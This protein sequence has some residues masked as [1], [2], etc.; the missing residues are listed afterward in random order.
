MAVEG[1]WNSPDKARELVSSDQ[2]DC[3]CVS[4]EYS[5][6]GLKC[7]FYVVGQRAA[8]DRR[9]QL[10]KEEMTLPERLRKAYVAIAQ[11]YGYVGSIDEAADMIEELQRDVA[12]WENAHR[13]AMIERDNFK[14]QA[15]I[16]AQTIKNMQQ[17]YVDF[18]PIFGGGSQS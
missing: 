14:Q 5:D 8:A 3:G 13:V 2:C 11:V 18:S 7:P 9:A 12:R 4:D 17:G 6:H 15:E 1:P 16:N 10:P